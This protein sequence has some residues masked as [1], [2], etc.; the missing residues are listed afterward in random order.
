MRCQ[1]RKVIGVVIHVVAARG[2]GRA[3]MA[4]AVMGYD[5]CLRK[6]SICVSQSS[7]DSGQALHS[8]GCGGRSRRRQWAVVVAGEIMPK[9]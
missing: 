7:A 3:T 8:L 9:A 4:T 2:L 1:R 5:A 6:N